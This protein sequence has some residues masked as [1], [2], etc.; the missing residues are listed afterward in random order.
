MAWKEHTFKELRW[1]KTFTLKYLRQHVDVIKMYMN[2]VRPYLRNIK[3]MQSEAMEKGK[4]RN[5][6][7]ASA[8]EGSVVELEFLGRLMP[9]GNKKYY[10][11]GLMHFLYRTRPTMS[12]MAEGYQRGPLHVG[13]IRID[14]RVYAWTEEDVQNYLK[15]REQ[16]DFEL[17]G[18]IDQS[19]RAA[20]EALGD[21]L[22]KYL[23]EA[24]EIIEKKEEPKKEVKQSLVD[25]FISVVKGFGE[26]LPKKSEAKK[27][28]KPSRKD[29][30]SDGK[31]IKAATHTG[32]WVVWLCYKNYKKAHRMIQW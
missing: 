25:P 3:R 32:K 31:E 29:K 30:F 23:E 14:F 4:D 18:I 5:P 19:V 1:R 10:S 7:I 6:D 2:W 11:C 9:E 13:E 22:Y 24:G 21:D 26:F 8:F 20:M 27:P 16:E 12:Y 15:M 28:K 17:I